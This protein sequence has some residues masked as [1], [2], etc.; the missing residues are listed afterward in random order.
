P[1]VVSI[2]LFITAGLLI[3]GE[4][5]T[6]RSEMLLD[7]SRQMGVTDSFIIGSAQALAI[8]PGVSRSGSTIAAGMA[9]G[10]DRSSATRF[11]FLLATPIILAAGVMQA[12]EVVT[13]EKSL[14]DGLVTALAAGFI[15]SAI[16]GFLC[17]LLLLRLVR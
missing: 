5:A 12:F 15:S 7:D 14:D 2:N 8:L 1:A 17:I 4:W 6:R 10:M 3:Y 9:R 16:V 11:S 13:S